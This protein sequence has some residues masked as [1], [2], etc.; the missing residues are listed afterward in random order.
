MY[1]RHRVRP[2]AIALVTMTCL[3]LAAC[4][5][6]E[7]AAS[8]PTRSEA[9]SSPAAANMLSGEWASLQSYIDKYP[10]QSGLLDNSIITAPLQNLLGSKHAIFIDNMKVQS[11]LSRD[12][13]VLYTSGN[14][15]HQGGSDA[16]YLLIDT[17][18]RT[19]EVGL[20]EGGKLSTF[21]AGVLTISKPADI[22]T[23][24]AN[25]AG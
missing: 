7:P 6:N 15:P 22:Q 2:A 23:M 16:A 20:W 25:A 1:E 4:G 8:V 18:S 21:P 3:A 9:P 10:A 17:A 14:K 13:N 24:I 5:S 11:P 12:E 19:L